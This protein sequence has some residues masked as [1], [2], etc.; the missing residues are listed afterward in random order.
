MSEQAGENFS[1]IPDEILLQILGLLDPQSRS[2]ISASCKR[3]RKVC[4]TFW[5]DQC[6]DIDRNLKGF[7][8]GRLS[9]QLLNYASNHNELPTLEEIKK[10]LNTNNFKFD[11]PLPEACKH[12]LTQI[13][14]KASF[15]GQ[16]TA[17]VVCQ[18]IGL[19]L[20]LQYNGE[21]E[22][23]QIAAIVNNQLPKNFYD[24][25]FLGRNPTPLHAAARGGHAKCAL[26]LLKHGCNVNKRDNTGLCPVHYVVHKS[27][28]EV[29]KLL[30]K[31]KANLS[32][33]SDKKIGIDLCGTPLH[34]AAYSSKLGILDI[35][36]AQL[37]HYPGLTNK[38]DSNG[39]TPL[40]IACIHR[41]NN[42]VAK[43]L[44]DH[45]ADPALLNKAGKTPLDLITDY[46]RRKDLQAYK[47]AEKLDPESEPESESKYT[48]S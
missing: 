19:D 34:I 15:Q 26:F 36:L 22:A 2:Q 48:C 47:L 33:M 37:E 30:C 21:S 44:I 4:V 23:G 17:L 39:N 27:N 11:A 20:N 41:T 28:E 18:K 8:D 42:K 9:M 38:P 45:G 12:G 16:I 40:H 46:A 14:V 3:F 1:K 25:R 7:Y 13:L 32:I 29:L 6:K 10:I 31:C 43:L 24:L 5:Q 35:L